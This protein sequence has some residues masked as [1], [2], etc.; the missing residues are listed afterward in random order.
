MNYV[1]RISLRG[2]RGGLEGEMKKYCIL[3]YIGDKSWL[4]TKF[5]FTQMELKPWHKFVL[6]F[7]L[8]TLK[9]ELNIGVPRS[10]TNLKLDLKERLFFFCFPVCRPLF[11]CFPVE[12]LNVL[13]VRARE[14]PLFCFPVC[15]RLFFCFPA[16]KLNVLIVRAWKLPLS[17]WM[18]QFWSSPLHILKQWHHPSTSNCCHC[19]GFLISPICPVD[20]LPFGT[21]PLAL[22][23]ILILD[24]QCRYLQS[25]DQIYSS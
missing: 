7:S 17:V 3:Y 14:L 11:F 4:F 13:I 21:W 22:Q 8:G 1:S 9:L 12:K 23:F 6:S 20:P 24:L 5:V 10:E 2:G 25:A 19:W 15:R 16:E 18:S